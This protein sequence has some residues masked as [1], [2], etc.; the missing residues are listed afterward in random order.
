M[1]HRLLAVAPVDVPGG[2]EV[3]LLRLL[4]GLAPR[5]WDV[6]LTTPGDG[7]LRAEAARAGY[8]WHRLPVGGLERGAGARALAS[9]PRARKLAAEHDVVYL[10]GAV[11]GRLLPALPPRSAR[12]VLHIHDIV[13]RVPRFWRRADVV[14]ADSLAVARR[15]EPQRAG[16]V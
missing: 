12:R 8:S 6:A 5:G 4:A 16:V 10:N 13:S 14:L 3:H 15:H 2:A 9:W 7:P 1:S 11:C